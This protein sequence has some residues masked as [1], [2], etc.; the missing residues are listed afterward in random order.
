MKIFAVN[1]VALTAISI[2]HIQ[3][4]NALDLK[5]PELTEAE[6]LQVCR[7]GNNQKIG[8]FDSYMNMLR[9]HGPIYFL[10]ET[11]VPS[12]YKKQSGFWESNGIK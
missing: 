12:I 8:A 1:D 5:L 11:D 3:W 10:R 4:F 2:G 9:E 6:V 7:P